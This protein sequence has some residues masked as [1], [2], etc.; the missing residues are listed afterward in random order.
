[1]YED[2]WYVTEYTNDQNTPPSNE[3]KTPSQ[4]RSFQQTTHH[5]SRNR[6][7]ALR[8]HLGA[9]QSLD[10]RTHGHGSRSGHSPR[11]SSDHLSALLTLPN[12]HARSLHGVLATEGTSI[13]TRQFDFLNVRAVLRNLN[14]LHNLT[15]RR[16][17][18]RS[19]LSANSNLLSSLTL[20]LRYIP[21]P[22]DVHCPSEPRHSNVTRTTRKKA[23]SHI[24]Y[25]IVLLP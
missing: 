21:F 5:Y 7:L 4:I 1:M 12:T 23:S 16:T 15:Q 9:T 10:G 20:C 6:I 22:T 3:T 19:I 2:P 14:L 24:T 17:V 13:A 18:S 25:H 8:L 11:T